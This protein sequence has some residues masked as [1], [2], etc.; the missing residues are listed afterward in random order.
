MAE[1]I[2]KKKISGIQ[3]LR[4]TATV[5]ILLHHLPIL[6]VTFSNSLGPFAVTIFLCITG[7]LAGYLDKG[8][9]INLSIGY[10]FKRILRI[11]KKF[12]WIWVLIFC[13][14]MIRIIA[15]VGIHGILEQNFIVK[16]VLFLTFTQAWVPNS[17]YYF[18]I[19]GPCW[20]MSMILA[21]YFVQPY[22]VS[23]LRKF[24]VKA[25]LKIWGGV[26]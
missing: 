22:I 17:E 7:F 14:S 13:L 15:A 24:D 19:N 4:I 1:N 12:Y 9:T 18:A 5:M 26:A 10:Q 3:F 23:W 2:V 11:A 20:Y 8:E 25:L 16:S 21:V 6:G